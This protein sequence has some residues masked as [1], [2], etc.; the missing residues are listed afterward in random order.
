MFLD[1]D[2]WSPPLGDFI[3]MTVTCRHLT[4][5]HPGMEHVGGDSVFSRPIPAPLAG[6]CSFRDS[7][8]AMQP[9]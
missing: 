3:D 9:G 2:P 6:D 8:N 5:Q 4:D 7:V 1:V